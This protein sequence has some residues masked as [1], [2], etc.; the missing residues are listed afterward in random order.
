MACDMSTETL[1]FKF[2]RCW[3]LFRGVIAGTTPWKWPLAHLLSQVPLGWCTG[4]EALVLQRE[5]TRVRP[6]KC[7]K[8]RTKQYKYQFSWSFKF[9]LVE[10]GATKNF[11]AFAERITTHNYVAVINAELRHL[12]YPLHMRIRT[13]RIKE[14]RQEVRKWWRENMEV[15]TTARNKKIH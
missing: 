10:S 12:C 15:G 5:H 13:A 2:V 14:E 6:I 11:A 9:S 8:Q 1:N 3:H 7:H 4:S